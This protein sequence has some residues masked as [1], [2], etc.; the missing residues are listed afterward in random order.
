M[1]GGGVR[2]EWKRR[3][4]VV[5]EGGRDEK[6]GLMEE[7]VVVVVEVKGES[8]RGWIG[9]RGGGGM[10]GKRVVEMRRERERER[11]EEFGR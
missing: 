8:V 6:G 10:E 11:E 3:K 4:E 2:V 7:E 9:G 1:G 5:E